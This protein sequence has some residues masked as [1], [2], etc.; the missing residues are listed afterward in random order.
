[1]SEASVEIPQPAAD[2]PETSKPA[3]RSKPKAKAKPKAKKKSPEKMP[4][5]PA[6]PEAKKKAK[7]AKRSKPKA[8]KPARKVKSKAKSAV[9]RSHRLDLRLTAAE[10]AKLTVR[11]KKARRTITSLVTELI[12]K[13][14]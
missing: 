14:K 8:R 2:K 7:P 3:K 13:L 10:K 12:E 6:K 11:A 4:K 1:M 9:V 5:R